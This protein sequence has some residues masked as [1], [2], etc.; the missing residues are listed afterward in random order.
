VVALASAACSSS[1]K[2]SSSASTTRAKGSGALVRA[3]P[4]RCIASEVGADEAPLSFAADGRV[5]AVNPTDP[6]AVHCLFETDDV[7]LF[8]WGPRGDR[9]VLRGMEVRGVG[10]RAGRPNAGVRAS[11]FSWS[12]PTGTT[13]VFID[14][15]RKK[16]E[17]ADMGGSATRDIT[18][19][20]GLTYGDVAYH[21]SGLAIGYVAKS[22]TEAGIWIASNQGKDPKQLVHADMT[23]NFG[24]LV[25][26]N[27]GEALY[28]SVD[29][30]NAHF[31]AQLYLSTGTVS[32]LLWIGDAPILDIVQRAALPGVGLTVGDTCAERSAYFSDLDGT[33]GTQLAPQLGTPLSVIDRLDTDMF[34]VAAGGCDGATSDLYLVSRTG[35]P[36]PRLIVADVDA[37]A[38][39][40]AEPTPPP[41]LPPEL[42]KAGAA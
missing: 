30:P 20:S 14:P 11:Y 15:S 13:V 1:S 25:F 22:A 4:E 42:P 28:Y 37:A 17:R 8:S 6:S 7:G 34:V 38:S 21:P 24:H 32:D 10:S 39:R 27:D 31:L 35:T 19:Q 3:L 18:P 16:L 33:S 5:W 23:T 36:A 12:R 2:S 9:V 29:K 26:R 41:P 40:A